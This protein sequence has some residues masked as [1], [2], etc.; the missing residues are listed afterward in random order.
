M[1]NMRY[2]AEIFKIIHNEIGLAPKVVSYLDDE[3]KTSIDIYIGEDRPDFGL[4]TYSTIG[5]SE[6]SIDLIDKKN[7]PIRVEL[8]AVCE[9]QVDKF[10]N[11][12]ASCA[13][14]IIKNNYSCSPSTVNMNAISL[15]Y[16]NLEMK[17][18]YYTMPYLW[19][20]LQG[21]ELGGNVVNWLLAIPIS[22]N[23]LRFL[24]ENGA[25]AFEDLLEKHE[26]EIFDIYRKSIV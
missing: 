5:L 22:E 16:D 25:D 1:Q 3:E 11:V 26:I 2:K 12:I 17:H 14:D 13:F 20:G 7:I 10:A 19:D 23:E 6:Y 15:Y 21:I 24:D 9:S 4:T 8:I 18:I